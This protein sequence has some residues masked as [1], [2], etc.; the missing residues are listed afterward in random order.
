MVVALV[1]AVVALFVW[2]DRRDHGTITQDDADELVEC[3]AGP[4]PE[5]C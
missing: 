2:E 5:D 1:V 3:L 4:N